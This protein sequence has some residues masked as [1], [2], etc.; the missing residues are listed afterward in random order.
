MFPGEFSPDDTNSKLHA[1]GPVGPEGLT[2]Y[3]YILV[4]QGHTV[5]EYTKG[6]KHFHHKRVV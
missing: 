5:G 6:E 4:G 1:R 2:T 3:K